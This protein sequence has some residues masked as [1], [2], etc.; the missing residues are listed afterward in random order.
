MSFIARLPSLQF[1]QWPAAAQ[2]SSVQTECD[3]RLGRIDRLGV[4]LLRRRWLGRRE[5]RRGARSWDQLLQALSLQKLG[6]DAYVYLAIDD[7]SEAPRRKP[8][9]VFN[10]ADAVERKPLDFAE[11][12][13]RLLPTW[14]KENVTYCVHRP[15]AKAVHPFPDYPCPLWNITAVDC[16]V[17]THD[18]L[19]YAKVAH[20]RPSSFAFRSFARAAIS[21]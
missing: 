1:P 18:L 7:G 6:E 4:R 12:N 10:F 8:A 3:I 2:P 13:D 16:I 5:G 11:A 20:M 19:A 17:D 15:F 9:F 14:A 21:S